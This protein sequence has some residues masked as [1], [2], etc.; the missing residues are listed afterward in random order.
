MAFTEL[1]G[2]NDTLRVA[3]V[4]RDAP[5]LL[6][7]ERVS[8]EIRAE[9]SGIFAPDEKFLYQRGKSPLPRRFIRGYHLRDAQT[10]KELLCLKGTKDA[11][12]HPL[13]ACH[14]EETPGH[15]GKSD[16]L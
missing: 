7:A 8:S 2:N 9:V 1:R 5:D 6:E 3:P 11:G 13:A 16:T 15:K 4:S 14:Q 10:G 12:R